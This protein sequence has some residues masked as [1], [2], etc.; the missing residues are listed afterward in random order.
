MAGACEGS[1]FGIAA[2]GKGVA[3]DVD[4]RAHGDGDVA[5]PHFAQHAVQHL[6]AGL[7]VAKGGRK[8]Q[9]IEFR[10]GQRQRHGEGIVYVIAD[11]GVDDDLL[12][13]GLRLGRPACDQKSGNRHDR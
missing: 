9:H 2:L 4:R 5:V 3:V 11:I 1:A 8:A 7:G 6:R 13:R 10:A 12:A